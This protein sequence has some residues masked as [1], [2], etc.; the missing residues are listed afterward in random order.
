MSA[1]WQTKYGPR[2]VRRN[3]PTLGEAL[4]AAQGLTDDR[5]QQVAIAAGLM[6][7]PVDDARAE[8][9][10]MA[11]DRRATLTMVAP[12]RDKGS[13]TVVVERK[14]SRRFITPPP[15]AIGAALRPR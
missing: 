5:E 12:S 13:R 2:R 10:R 3:P 1:T 14:T 7:V 8:L 15:R 6:G 11:P 4:V 9:R